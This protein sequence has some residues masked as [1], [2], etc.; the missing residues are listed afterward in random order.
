MVSNSEHRQAMP[1]LEILGSPESCKGRQTIPPGFNPRVRE[2]PKRTESLRD[3]R[4]SAWTVHHEFWSLPVDDENSLSYGER[5]WR[6]DCL[7][8]GLTARLKRDQ[9]LHF[10]VEIFEIDKKGM[11]NWR[12]A[13]PGMRFIRVALGPSAAAAGL[14]RQRALSRMGGMFSDRLPGFREVSYVQPSA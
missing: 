12:S 11:P 2:S 1:R 10:M 14:L 6:K 4:K 9:A 7:V 5:Y 8:N 3:D 13:I